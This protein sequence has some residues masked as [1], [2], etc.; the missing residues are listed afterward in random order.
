[1]T[2]ASAHVDMQI[3]ILITLQTSNARSAVTMTHSAGVRVSFSK[4]MPIFYTVKRSMSV[5][6]GASGVHSISYSP[7]DDMTQVAAGCSSGKISLLHCRPAMPD[8]QSL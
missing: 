2:T 6:S 3:A 5:E 8:Q 1:M 4:K 7:G